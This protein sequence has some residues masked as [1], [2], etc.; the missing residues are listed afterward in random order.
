MNIETEF[1]VVNK[2]SLYRITSIDGQVSSS[3]KTVFG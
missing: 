2:H 1:S 3:L